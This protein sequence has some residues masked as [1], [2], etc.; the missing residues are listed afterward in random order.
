MK[1]FISLVMVLAGLYMTLVYLGIHE[2][3]PRTYVGVQTF[4]NIESALSFQSDIVREATAIGA[5]ITQCDLTKQSPP[6]VSFRIVSPAESYNLFGDIPIPFKY[7]EPWESQK[8]AKTSNIIALIIVPS[9]LIGFL[10]LTWSKWGQE[11]FRE[12]AQ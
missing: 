10:W 6:T 3:G 12:T 2:Q 8:S 5:E 11:H 1:I 7:G 4:S 9:M